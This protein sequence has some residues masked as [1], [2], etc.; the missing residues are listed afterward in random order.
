MELAK[1]YIFALTNLYGIVHKDKVIEIFNKQNS[2]K[3]SEIKMG[4]KSISIDNYSVT[5]NE[6]NKNLVYLY[7][8]GYFANEYI[9]H[10]DEAEL[11]LEQQKGKPYYIPNKEKLLKYADSLYFEK[12]KEYFDLFKFIKNELVNGDEQLADTICDD[13][14][15]NIESSA[16]LTEIFNEFDR[17]K[18]YFDNDKQAEQAVKLIMELSNHTRLWENKGHTPNELFTTLEKPHLKP[19]P[20]E[21]F[22]YD[23]FRSIKTGTFVTGEKTDR[24]DPCPCG[25]G[26]K[27]K[28][29]CLNKV[30]Q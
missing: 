21:R 26:K 25:S 19:L 12:T 24:N 13:I 9:I 27:Y 4:K 3:I 16:S 28:K 6:L 15:V 8:D 11:L 7:K 2:D 20:A 29:C 14:Q 23:N 22:E 30:L 10:F 18:V 5:V 17:R 1:N